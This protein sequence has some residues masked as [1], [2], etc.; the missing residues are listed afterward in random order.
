[1]E[2]YTD[3]LGSGSAT[4]ILN[5]PY[6]PVQQVQLSRCWWT[7]PARPAAGWGGASAASKLLFC[8]PEVA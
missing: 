5:E 1:M 4:L 2:N 7:L 6:L 8:Q 3:S